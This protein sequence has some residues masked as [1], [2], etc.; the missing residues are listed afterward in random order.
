MVKKT[1]VIEWKNAAPDDILWVYPY[2]DIRWGSVVVV[3]E[4]EVAVFMRDG[5]IYDVLQP[6][7][8]VLTTQNLPLLTRAFRFL[9]GYGETPFKA[10][11]VFVSL[12]QFQG[13]FGT[14]LRLRLSPRASWMTEM[15]TYGTFWYRIADP[16]LFLTQI[17]GTQPH[18]T[19]EDVTNFLRSYFNEVIIQELSKYSVLEVQTKLED[20]V[21]DMKAGSLYDSFRQKGL[22]LIDVKF[23][24]VSFPYLEKLEREDPTYGVA[25]MSALQSGDEARVLETVKVVES[26]RALGKAGGAAMGA[27]LVAIPYLFG[28]QPYQQPPQ[29][30]YQQ[31]YQQ[32]PQPPQQPSKSGAPD[33]ELGKIKKKLEMLKELYEDGLIT[34]EE[35]K[36]K[37]KK[38]LEEML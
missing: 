11:V 22:E 19:S 20:I 33:D 30:P 12:K 3:K 18:F 5:K 16:V 32:P 21:M 8:H 10:R 27:G 37:K 31:A 4:S 9:A 13:K 29:Q 6:G 1:N 7:R 2:E 36:A 17:A 34:E 38:L 14:K 35:Y 24:G 28:G 26:M 15:Q 23:Q 25:L